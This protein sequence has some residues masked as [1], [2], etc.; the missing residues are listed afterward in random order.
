MKKFEHLIL[1]VKLDLKESLISKWFI[2]YMLFFGIIIITF[3]ITG[4]NKSALA[5][6]SGLNRLLLMYIQI[7]IAILPIFILVTTVKSIVKDRVSH[8]LEYLLSFPISLSDYYWGRFIG[9]LIT[10]F[11]PV[12]FA[13]ILAVIIGAFQGDFTSS[14]IFALY[15]MLIFS[16][17]WFFVSV[18][19]FISTIAKNQD[20]AVGISFGVWL[21]LLILLDI[22]L[23]EFLMQAKFNVP[24]YV[25]MILAL[26]NPLE[27]FRIAAIMLF[28][29]NLAT[30]GPV[31]YY[32]LDVFS[33]AM[34]L[35]LTFCYTIFLGFI[36][37]YGGVHLFKK[38][39]LL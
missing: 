10:V 35:L 7:T 4:V 29:Y 22:I 1:A 20:T 24:E 32:I 9:R 12:L 6:F 23:L 38:R 26:L 18:A 36:F 16:L 17:S 2:F 37:A 30:I 15:C 34:F 3:F 39:D 33:N 27:L 21:L 25:I 8:V 31:A 5:G 14:K 19:F 11:I 28:D 13:L